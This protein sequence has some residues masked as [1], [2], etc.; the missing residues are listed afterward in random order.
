MRVFNIVL[1]HSYLTHVNNQ[2]NK[3]CI[4]DSTMVTDKLISN[5][6]DIIH[7]LLI[8]LINTVF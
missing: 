8:Y 2:F 6:D 4:L 7:S 5:T 3:Y 1:H